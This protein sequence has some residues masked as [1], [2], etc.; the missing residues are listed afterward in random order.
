ML[1]APS[2]DY[3]ICPLEER[4]R[5]RQ[6]EGMG[7]L[8][9]DDEIELLRLLDG[10][11]AGPRTLEDLVDV[12]HERAFSGIWR[13]SRDDGQPSAHRPLHDCCSMSE[14]GWTVDHVERLGPRSAHR[15][16]RGTE[17]MRRAFPRLRVRFRV[18]WTEALLEHTRKGML[19]TAIVYFP[20]DTAA[21]PKTTGQGITTISLRFVAPRTCRVGPIV[22]L[23]D[24]LKER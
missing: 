14:E 6:A 24:I 15:L 9:V 4:R 1:A 16:E 21:P 11:V 18:D 10:Q 3:V 5:D 20:L 2:F 13:L 8:E 23:G 22:D 12:R 19:D 17:Q 7:G